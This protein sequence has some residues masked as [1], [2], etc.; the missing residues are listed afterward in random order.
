[1]E[2]SVQLSLEQEFALRKFARQ[3]QTLSL[4]ESQALLVELN[5]HMMM[6]DNVYKKLLKPC[7]G[8]G[9]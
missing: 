5:R 2:Q 4:E 8:S 7:L 3:V 9:K 6:R 1:M